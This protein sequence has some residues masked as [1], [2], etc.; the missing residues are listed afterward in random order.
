MKTM[1]MIR[2][3]FLI[4]AGTLLLTACQ[5]NTKQ[6]NEVPVI[7]VTIEPQRYFAEAIAGD[8]FKIETMV[9]KGSS[10]ETYDPTPQQLVKLANSTAYLR[11]G[12][13]GFEQTWMEKLKSN[14]PKMHVFNLS[15]GVDLIADCGHSHE[16]WEE[17]Q[18]KHSHHGVEP[19]IWNSTRNAIIIARNTLD[20]L[21]DLDAAD[22][23]Y[24]T[25][26]YDSLCQVIMS[27][28]STI[29]KM[30]P[31][32]TNQQTFMIYHP[33]LSYFARDY[34]LNQIS[35]EEEGKTPSPAHM[36]ELV[37]TCRRENVKV[38]FVQP[39]FDKRNAEVI[40]KE[41]GLK[42]IDIN[43]LNYDWREEMLRVATA[44]SN[45]R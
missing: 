14:A 11:I 18:A 13:L 9:P 3:C 19:H 40:A 20:A 22:K 12:Y 42:I 16:E 26:R 10:P 39:E 32:N 6:K 21:I 41:T 28:D 30:L 35:I 43:P 31:L 24:F 45:N 2:N 4:M 36:K 7:T 34:F 33:A 38:I 25:A 15:E 29:V 23:D 17:P 8:K 1:K 27:T 5:G 37:E 44:L